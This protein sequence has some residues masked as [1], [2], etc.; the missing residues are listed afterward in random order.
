MGDPEVLLT[1]QNVVE[2]PV[3]PIAV[4]HVNPDIVVLNVVDDYR[5]QLIIYTVFNIVN[6]L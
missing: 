1:P 3:F 6:Q 5:I 2:R 4:L